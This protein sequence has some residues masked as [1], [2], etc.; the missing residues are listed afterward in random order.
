MVLVW[1][2]SMLK[3]FVI[4]R[5]EAT[6]ALLPADVICLTTII[7]YTNFLILFGLKTRNE[8]DQK[9][10][11]HCDFT[12]VAWDHISKIFCPHQEFLF[13]H[14]LSRH[15]I[16][17]MGWSNFVIRMESQLKKRY[18][19]PKSHSKT[20]RVCSF[21][22]FFARWHP[23]CTVIYMLILVALRQISPIWFTPYGFSS[24]TLSCYQVSGFLYSG[25]SLFSCHSLSSFVSMAT[26]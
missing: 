19:H 18:S 1:S 12:D 26:P 16:C 6:E 11:A 23:M 25:V 3:C 5:I 8:L 4:T 2:A 9:M 15:F 7:A 14:I 17:W 20:T 21:F 24:R 22:S 10:S 13:A